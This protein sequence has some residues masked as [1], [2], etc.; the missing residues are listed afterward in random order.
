MES[1]E[2][3]DTERRAFMG[4]KG[5]WV[6]GLHVDSLVDQIGN[7]GFPKQ[8]ITDPLA[9]A[10]HS[11]VVRPISYK[12]QRRAVREARRIGIADD[13][14]AQQLEMFGFADRE[15]TGTFAGALGIEISYFLRNK[16][17]H[18]SPLSL[19]DYGIMFQTGWFGHIVNQI[20]L[21]R[22]TLL[23]PTV[24]QMN[25]DKVLGKDRSLL[26]SLADKTIPG[27]NNL[28]DIQ[29]FF[30]KL[31]KYNDDLTEE[32]DAIRQYIKLTDRGRQFFTLKIDHT[33][34][35]GCP[36]ARSSTVVSLQDHG[37]LDGVGAL[38]RCSSDISTRKRY[39][40]TE[41]S[42][43]TPIDRVLWYWGDYVLRYANYLLSFSHDQETR[44]KLLPSG[45]IGSD[46]FL[47]PS[48]V[49]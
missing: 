16:R 35:V 19:M 22:P 32:V 44:Y 36:V 49:S 46:G 29:D 7:L 6:Y 2:S 48:I 1:I 17:F 43:Y 40:L 20:A 45:Q 34:G 42:A 39:R 38:D 23:G 26:G 37:L 41:P 8:V 24:N 30:L 10:A 27:Y 47:C 4:G 5:L 9:L 33:K 25:I 12:T 3:K 31:M 21:T 28:E 15:F 13:I 11:K 14:G 18:Q